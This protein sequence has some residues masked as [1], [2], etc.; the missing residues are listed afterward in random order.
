MFFSRKFNL[1][2]TTHGLKPTRSELKVQF[3]CNCFNKILK[4]CA[5]LIRDCFL[6]CNIFSCMQMLSYTVKVS[7]IFLIIP[8]RKVSG[9]N[10]M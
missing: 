9:H 5:S 3:S 6:F 10:E 2:E 4:F 1:N 8:A 7:E